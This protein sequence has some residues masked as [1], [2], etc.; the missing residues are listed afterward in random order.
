[1]WDDTGVITRDEIAIRQKT[2]WVP[3]TVPY[4]QTRWYPGPYGSWRGDCS[5]FVSGT[6]GLARSY[7]TVDLPD[8]CTRIDPADLKIGDLIGLM[9]PGT[10]GDA[11]HVMSFESRTATGLVIWEQAGGTIGQRRRTI[12][13]IP[14]GYACYRYNGLA[15]E[16]KAMSYILQDGPSLYVVPGGLASSGK[17]AAVAMYGDV[18]AAHANVLP[19]VVLP[20]G[21]NAAAA[22]YDTN[23][24]PWNAATAMIEHFHNVAGVTG[25]VQQGE[26][27]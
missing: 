21:V 10:G 17:I 14:A 18:M 8:V 27:S 1:M 13:G 20:A 5:G 15:P 12:K 24:K 3:G 9:G 4:S 2:V 16:R 22:G 6:L 25:P 7:S 23:P 26:P 11:G 19:T